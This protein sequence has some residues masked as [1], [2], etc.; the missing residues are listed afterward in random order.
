[1]LRRAAWIVG[2]SVAIVV[3]LVGLKLGDRGAESTGRVLDGADIDDPGLLHVH[4]LGVNP[5]DQLLYVASHTGLF[6]LDNDGVLHRVAGRYQDTMG[7][8]VAGPNHF[9]ASGHPDLRERLPSRLGFIESTNAGDSWRPLS[10][11]GMADFHAIAVAHGNVYASDATLGQLLVSADAGMTW[12]TRGSATLAALA[13]DPVDPDHLIGADHEGAVVVTTD[14]GRTWDRLALPP[15]A[16]IVWDAD[17]L[18]GLGVDGS[19]MNA[20]SPS[21]SWDIVGGVGGA[22]AALTS[23]AGSVY[24]AT[25]PGELLR[26][27]DRGRTWT[28]LDANP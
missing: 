7:F 18:I 11:Q 12:A 26:S 10:L 21:G 6:R 25:E 22:G 15:L 1:M 23:F 8:T 27:D 13:V 9:V 20:T 28:P 19:V 3:A 16:A 24:A 17:G 4:G 5:A 14:G 2:G